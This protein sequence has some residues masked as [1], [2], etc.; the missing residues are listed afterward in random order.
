METMTAQIGGTVIRL[1]QEGLSISLPR[2]HWSARQW[3]W[4]VE[5]LAQVLG[6]G[7]GWVLAPTG[8][9]VGMA[10]RDAPRWKGL[11]IDGL[12]YLLFVLLIPSGHPLRK[13]YAAF[14]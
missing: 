14:D 10:D 13:L 4:L 2:S 7:M 5:V 11:V 6:S 3:A 9:G 12:S 1:T 8:G